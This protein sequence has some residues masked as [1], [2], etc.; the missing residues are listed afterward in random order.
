MPRTVDIPRFTHLVAHDADLTIPPVPDSP[1]DVEAGK[2]MRLNAVARL[3]LSA[4]TGQVTPNTRR[5]RRY[6]LEGFL[7]H[8]GGDTAVRA[9][10]R[11]HI[12]TWLATQ[13]VSPGTLKTRF[14]TV[15]S[16]FDLAV[17]RR[18][19]RTSPCHGIVL[20]RQPRR[21]PRAFSLVELR[22]LREALPDE[23]ARLIV[24]LGVCEGLRRVE[25]AR[26]E[27]GD[28]DLRT[29]TI[30]VLTAKTGN[31]DLI[32]LTDVT[33]R[34]LDEYL[35]VRGRFPGPLIQSYR[36]RGGIT[37]D[38]IGTLVVGWLRD[39]GVKAAPFDGRS[40]HACR[41]TAAMRML[42]AGADPTIIQ[43]GLRHAA[44]SSTWTYL[45]A[46]RN[47]DDLRQWMGADMHEPGGDA[48]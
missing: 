30:R 23:R 39:A 2:I 7:A 6:H 44:L 48:A 35:T 41:H 8:M 18:W 3:Y 37:A 29:R 25:I 28:I 40:L 21:Q 36:R 14:L 17:E 46:R 12:E 31:E 43:A 13:E 33:G 24:S 32:P 45:R 11:R 1:G 34:Y 26:L 27:L 19:V 10:K 42:E 15:R 16:M 22:A 5:Q 38:T 4:I 47:V 9:V 20:P